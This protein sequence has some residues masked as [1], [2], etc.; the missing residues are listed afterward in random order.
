MVLEAQIFFAI[1][2]F[3]LTAVGCDVAESATSG[4]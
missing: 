1:R 4:G 3:I 2:K